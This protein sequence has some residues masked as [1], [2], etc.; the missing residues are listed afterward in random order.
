MQ[1][2]YNYVPETNH[3]WRV[4]SFAA[5]IHGTCNV[6]SHAEC[7]ALWHHHFPQFVCA[8]HNMA[9]CCSSLISPLPSMLFGYCLSDFALVP[10]AP[11]VSG[12]TFGFYFHLRYFSIVRCL[13]FLEFSR[14]LSWSQFSPE[15]TCFYTKISWIMTS[16]LL[17]G[18]VLSVCAFWFHNIV[19]F[20]T[21]FC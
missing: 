9:V 10:V 13:Y 14:L 7:F 3:A 17:T 20:M 15:Y 18:V 19:T 21:C 16:G 6:N 4:C 8:V 5:T 12:I 2:I 1:G 11:V